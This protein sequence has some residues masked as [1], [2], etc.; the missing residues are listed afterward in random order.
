MFQ[1]HVSSLTNRLFQTAA[2]GLFAYLISIGAVHAGVDLNG[3]G[4]SD[5]WQLIF[6]AQGVD[7]KADADGDGQTN[8]QESIAG[9]DPF[10]ANS[11]FKVTKVDSAGGNITLHWP[12]VRG[13]RYQVYSSTNLT[14]W[15]A[16][17]S[18]LAGTGNELTATLAKGSAPNFFRVNVSD[19]DT[20]GDGVNDWEEIQVG[21]DPN[22]TSTDGTNT[23]YNRVV[24]ALQAA[25]A[26]LTVSEIDPVQTQDG[27]TPGTFTISRSGRLD[28]VTVTYNLNG[29][30]VPGTDY[31]PLSG[32]A[33]VPF[34]FGPATVQV[35]AI[36]GS[37]S[38]RTLTMN[39][40]SAPPGSGYQLG[41]PS[42]AREARA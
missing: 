18:V 22:K 10:N 15:V 31:Q 40:N 41:T 3:D 16:V 14:S 5:I 24:A 37:T 23:D 34:G 21:L 9:T 30:A 7:P 27:M 11:A 8:L 1:H 42:S 33:T 17:G 20:D 19:V 4:M 35:T 29:T 6:H 36:S 39:L 28:P 26:T 32:T 13:K 2:V 25:S 38:T 12:S